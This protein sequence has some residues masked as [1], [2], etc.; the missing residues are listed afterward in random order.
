MGKSTVD[1]ANW[2]PH[3]SMS[4]AHFTWSS[5]PLAEIPMTLTLRFA[6][7]GALFNAPGRAQRQLSRHQ[8]T[9]S[10]IPTR[11][12]CKLGGADGSEVSRMREEYGLIMVV[13]TSRWYLESQVR[14]LIHTQE[15]PIHSWN[16]IVPLVVGASKSGAMSPR[17]SPIAARL[18]DVGEEGMRDV[19][20]E[21]SSSSQ[22]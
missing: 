20:S 1:G 6:K 11:N 5:R 12:F 9:G 21:I 3:S 13:S 19:G 2:A 22:P 14:Q 17:R 15:S 7:S 8:H 4:L 16:L 10:C 18:R